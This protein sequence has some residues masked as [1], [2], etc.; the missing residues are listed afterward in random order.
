MKE[1]ALIVGARQSPELY[2][3]GAKPDFDALGGEV[4]EI[5][6]RLDADAGEERDEIVGRREDSDWERGEKIPI[7]SKTD[8]SERVRC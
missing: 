1:P 7:V 3:I 6:A 8:E 4:G 2:A 5:G